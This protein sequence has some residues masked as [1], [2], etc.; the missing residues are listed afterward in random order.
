MR[1][2]SVALGLLSLAVVVALISRGPHPAA[3]A[4]TGSTQGHAAL[5]ERVHFAFDGVSLRAGQ[6]FVRKS[7]DAK[8]L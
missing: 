3:I 1:K 5:P 7:V 2:A 6:S 4:N 8:H